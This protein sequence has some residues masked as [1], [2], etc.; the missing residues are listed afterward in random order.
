IHMAIC[1]GLQGVGLGLFQVAYSDRVLATLPQSDR[2]VAGS[3]TLVTR[4]LGV[5]G[6]AA[7]LT[8]LNDALA[9]S[10]AISGRADA[11]FVGF[12]QTFAV[13]AAGLGLGLCLV[14][15]TATINR[16]RKPV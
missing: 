16:N 7:G 12:Q 9:A 2:G 15:A 10:A 1:L 4:T 5:I 13:V 6:A 8:A 3:L 11:A 14:G